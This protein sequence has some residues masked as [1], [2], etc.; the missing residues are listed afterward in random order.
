MFSL[1]PITMI[2]CGF[3]LVL[4]GFLAIFFMVIG[5]IETGLLL[6]FAGYGASFV[7][8]LLGIIGVAGYTTGGGG[9]R[10]E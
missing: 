8:L 10:Y 3:C 7:G 1:G 4:S 5:L 2:V 6:N 9:S